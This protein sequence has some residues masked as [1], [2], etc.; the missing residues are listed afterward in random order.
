[1]QRNN[2]NGDWQLGLHCDKIILLGASKRAQHF[3]QELYETA[4]VAFCH[5]SEARLRDAFLFKMKDFK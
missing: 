3:Y 2:H 1:M 5:K 4:F